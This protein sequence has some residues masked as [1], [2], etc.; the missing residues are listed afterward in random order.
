MIPARLVQAVAVLN[1][2]FLVTELTMNLLRT[3]FG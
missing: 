1:L 2:T 3:Y